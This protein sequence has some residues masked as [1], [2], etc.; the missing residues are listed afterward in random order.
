MVK[1]VDQVYDKL[2]PDGK[3]LL[4]IWVSTYD[5][6]VSNYTSLRIRRTFQFLDIYP[7]E[8]TPDENEV[9]DRRTASGSRM[10]QDYEMGY[11]RRIINEARGLVEL[12]QVETGQI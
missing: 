8:K 7:I 5:D 2:G 12:I 11:I 6:I 1:F 3:L 9:I 10:K 4:R